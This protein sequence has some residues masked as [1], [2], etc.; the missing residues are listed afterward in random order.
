MK[1]FNEFEN[2]NEKHY[3]K[4]FQLIFFEFVFFFVNLNCTRI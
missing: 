1:N 3:E 2:R 4:V